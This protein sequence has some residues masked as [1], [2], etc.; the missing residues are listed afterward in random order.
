MEALAKDTDRAVKDP[1]V[2]VGH[3]AV[4]SALL[5]ILNPNR[6]QEPSAV[7]YSTGCLNALRRV[8]GTW[9]ALMSARASD[10]CDA[11]YGRGHRR[12]GELEKRLPAPALGH[13]GRHDPPGMK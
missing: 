2:H 8:G 6:W 3:D 5:S 11:E 9:S 12:P 10:L 4:N 13:Q 7:P 1:V